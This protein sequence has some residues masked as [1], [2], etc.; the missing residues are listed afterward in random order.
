[1]ADDWYPGATVRRITEDGTQARIRPTQIILHSAG[2]PHSLF[3]MWQNGSNLES[4]AWAGYDGTFEQYMRCTV[5]ADANY[6]ANRRPDGTGAISVESESTIPATEP[7]TPQQVEA[8]TGFCVWACRTYSIPPHA[9]PSPDAPGIGYHVMF[10]APGPW[11]P[12]AKSCPGG[13]RIAQVPQIVA[14][15]ARRLAPPPPD[16][17]PAPPPPEEGI[18]LD[19][20]TI[21]QLKLIV[22][23]QVGA[24]LDERG[25]EGDGKPKILLRLAQAARKMNDY[26]DKQK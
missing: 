16:P 22:R 4:H 7:W 20:D 10:G 15:V 23:E 21:A 13:A 19:N 17:T 18:V 14:E 12:H 5:E 3:N 26:I 6:T 1:M 24:E 8:I 2:G 9:C 11:T 25:I